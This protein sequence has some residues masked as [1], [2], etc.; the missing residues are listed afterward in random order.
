VPDNE[1]GVKAA[2][3]SYS[4]VKLISNIKR[5]RELGFS[6]QSPIVRDLIAGVLP[7]VNTPMVALINSDII[8][9]PDFSERI[10]KIVKKYGYDIYMVGTRHDIDLKFTVN[11]SESYQK[12]LNEPRELY[13]VSTSSD[14]FIT[15]KFLWR[16]IIHEMPE[17][18]LGRYGWDNWLHTIAEVKGFRKFN[19]TS[20]LTTL[21]CR[22]NYQHILLQEQKQGQNAASS[23]HNLGLWSK[24]RDVYGTTRINAWPA[25]EIK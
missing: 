7:L 4:N 16:K 20:A 12:V 17:F 18:V 10:E 8:I 21:H 15:S 25:I 3:Q 5:A 19:C 6:N 1:I 13:D 2:C 9:L 22:H 14:I 23:Q 24:V 11:S